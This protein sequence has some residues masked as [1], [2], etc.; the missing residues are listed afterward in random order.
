MKN[1]HIQELWLCL[2][3]WDKEWQC[4]F[5]WWTKCEACAAPYLWLKLITWEVLHQKLDLENW[6]QKLIGIIN[7]RWFTNE[8]ID[9]IHNTT[10][11]FENFLKIIETYKLKQIARN[12]SNFYHDS[13]EKIDYKR[14]ETTAEHVYS[15]LKLADFFLDTEKEFCNLDRAKV[16][17]L[18]MYHDDIEIITEDTCIS[19]RDKREQK[20]EN[21][22]LAIP[23]LAIK[24]PNCL[25][26]KLL[27]LDVEFR[28]KNTVEAK[29]AEAIDKMDA[30]V[31]ELQY[32]ED[33]KPKNFG[34]ENVI[35]WF[36][37]SFEY[38][39]TFTKYFELVMKYLRE[40]NYV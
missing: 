5:W 18:L 38:S 32:K 24:Y 13:K 40:N 27:S 16:M 8:Y 28:E 23:E 30:L 20:F 21:E 7:N 22:K 26:D 6:K 31:H 11:N 29:F 33:W 15:C 2:D 3:I 39:P 34:A 37:P 36:K 25:K 12:C 19:D 17:D 1:T 10:H 35:K 4:G 14:K 9:S